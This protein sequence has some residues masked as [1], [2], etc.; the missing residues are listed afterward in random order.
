MFSNLGWDAIEI[1]VFLYVYPHSLQSHYG[2]RE[3]HG[4]IYNQRAFI[5]EDN[6]FL[7]LSGPNEP[8]YTHNKMSFVFNLGRLT[9][10]DTIVYPCF[11]SLIFNISLIFMNMQ[12]KYFSYRTISGW[13]NLSNCIT[14]YIKTGNNKGLKMFLGWNMFIYWVLLWF[15]LFF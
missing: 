3:N 6:I 12:M 5:F 8:I 9:L 4:I 7:H 13:E 2:L 1:W 11:F 15:Y 10:L 14:D